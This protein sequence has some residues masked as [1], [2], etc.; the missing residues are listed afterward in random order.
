MEYKLNNEVKLGWTGLSRN[1]KDEKA[2]NEFGSIDFVDS[3]YATR[4]VTETVEN[5]AHDKYGFQYFRCAHAIRWMTGAR[6]LKNKNFRAHD[7]HS[8]QVSSITL[9]LYI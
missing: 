4:K 8:I 2:A 6:L 7:R 3:F 1:R 9:S 5:V